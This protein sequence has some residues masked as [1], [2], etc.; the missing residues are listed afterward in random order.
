MFNKNEEIIVTVIIGAALILFLVSVFIVSIVRYKKRVVSELREKRILREQY[1]QELLQSKLEAQ[2]HAFQQIGKELHDNVGQ[3]L[4]T[5]RMLLGITERNLGT[6][7]ETLLTANQTLGQAIHELRTLSK[8]L[9]KDWLEQF[10][11][12]DN[13]MSEIARINH[14]GE[15][16]F[17]EWPAMVDIPLRSEEQI[18]LFRIVQE[19]IQNA[20]RHAHMSR[21]LIRVGQQEETFT[22]EV[23]DN[24]TGFKVA[25]HNAGM[26]LRNMKHRA[27]VLGG[28]VTWEALEEQGTAVHI[29][30]PRKN[31]AL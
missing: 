1:E 25:G 18:I 17:V 19:A 11:F 2:E 20:I 13:I 7:P 15:V 29:I 6:P 10:S 30:L 3:L 24:G 4:S 12:Y 31:N 14:T 27:N 22:V 8:S 16:I 21:M 26:G 5:A 9:D 28:T 23:H